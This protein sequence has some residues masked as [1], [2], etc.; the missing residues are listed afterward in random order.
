V[1]VQPWKCQATLDD[2]WR[3]VPRMP[4]GS[5]LVSL[6]VRTRSFDLPVVR[7]TPVCE[8][9]AEWEGSYAPSYEPE[10][11]AGGS[12]GRLIVA[13]LGANPYF[14]GN[15]AAGQ[16]SFRCR[17]AESVIWFGEAAYR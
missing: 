13:G 10:C 2:A 12:P 15:R 1:A 8:A 11:Y 4:D 6:G 16:P 3:R 7:S 14:L 9:Y 5:L 17:D